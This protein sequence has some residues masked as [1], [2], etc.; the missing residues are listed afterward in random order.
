MAARHPS[1]GEVRG[2][3]LMIGVDFV[4]SK[5]TKAYNSAL[6]DRIVDLAFE[7]GLLTL[8]CGKS[9]IRISP[10]LNITKEELVEGLE[11]FEKAITLAEQE[12]EIKIQHVA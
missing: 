5:E 7:Q 10:P 12:K 9:T 6:R 4:K 1:I 11:L 8:G 3:G 2:I